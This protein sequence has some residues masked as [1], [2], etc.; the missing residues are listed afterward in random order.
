MPP[1]TTV[2]IVEDDEATRDLY[3]HIL[4]AAGF[5]AVTVN[6][7]VEA[8][9]IIENVFLPGAIVLDLGLP[10]LGGLD[11]HAE[12][13]AH[14]ETKRIP[15]V[16]VTGIE[17]S[18]QQQLDFPFFLRKP[19]VAEALVLAVENALRRSSGFRR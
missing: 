13:R 2:L 19:V 4:R 18:P 3:R 12:L 8:L 15:I 10:R 1:A 9:H 5:H 6:D 14:A 16:V 7:G 17:L 11:L